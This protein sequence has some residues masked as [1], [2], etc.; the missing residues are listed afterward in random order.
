MDNGLRFL[1]MIQ[2]FSPASGELSFHFLKATTLRSRKRLRIFLFQLVKKEAKAAAHLSFVFC[3]DKHLLGL[4]RKFLRHDYYTDI[5]TFPLD[6]IPGA[7]HGEMYLSV[8]RIRE[9]A[10]QLGISSE[11]E[12]HRVIFHGVLHLCG[13]EDKTA[14]QI[15]EIRAREDF[16]LNKYFSR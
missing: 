14:A 4:N 8:D 15:K 6:P 2:M 9:N 1:E 11:Q 10:K 7:I 12:L 5:L 3:S 13:Y 16:Y